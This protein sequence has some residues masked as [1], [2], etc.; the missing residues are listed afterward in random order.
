MPTDSPHY[1]VTYQDAIDL[2]ELVL[3]A[4]GGRSGIL[5]ES[6]LL[7]ALARP[8]CGYFDSIEEKGSALLEAVVQNHGFADGNKRTATMLTLKLFAHSGYKLHPTNPQDD[9]GYGLENL[10]VDLASG[11]ITRD[12]VQTWFQVRLKPV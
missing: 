5:N 8:Y 2:H 1:V 4:S 9:L 11:Q 6:S 3:E 7:S 10:V 12:T